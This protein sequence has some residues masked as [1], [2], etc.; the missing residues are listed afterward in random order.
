MQRL[1]RARGISLRPGGTKARDN[2]AARN[3]A[4]TAM[5]RPAWRRSVGRRS[6]PAGCDVNMC[7]PGLRCLPML[8]GGRKSD[9]GTR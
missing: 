7:K 4:G 2:I 1:S 8:H 5:P 9:F 3:E 6:T